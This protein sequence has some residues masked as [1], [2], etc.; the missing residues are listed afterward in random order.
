MTT[1]LLLFHQ[2][3]QG[4]GSDGPLSSRTQ[5]VPFTAL[6]EDRLSVLDSSSSLRASLWTGLA[7]A[8][9]RGRIPGKL[10]RRAGEE[11]VYALRLAT[12]LMANQ[13][14]ICSIT[15]APW[16]SS[17]SK[18]LWRLGANHVSG[19][20]DNNE[21]LT[22]SVLRNPHSFDV[23]GEDIAAM[24]DEDDITLDDDLDL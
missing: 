23:Y 19:S 16:L 17:V 24:E 6:D 22:P 1:P 7:E 4:I 5:P 15:I 9:S 18:L 12:S 2:S 3:L 14:T 10:L 20:A 21:E 8:A 11:L 13:S